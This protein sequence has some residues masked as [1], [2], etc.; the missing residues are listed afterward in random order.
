MLYNS[1]LLRS[2]FIIGVLF[3]GASIVEGQE[4]REVRVQTSSVAWRTQL[5]HRL[6]QEL[7]SPRYGAMAE[8][9][10]AAG[11]AGMG[12][13]WFAGRQLLDSYEGA[14]LT[15][16]SLTSLAVPLG[17]YEGNGGSGELPLAIAAS[18]GIGLVG[19]IAVGSMW[20]DTALATGAV[21]VPLTQLLASMWV[22]AGGLF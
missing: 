7:E 13:G 15:A 22:V 6:A 16:A 9:G 12:I 2:L 10:L 18:F 8:G 20:T 17:V 14:F 5:E 1:H 19:V 11:V 3:M 4:Q 21:V